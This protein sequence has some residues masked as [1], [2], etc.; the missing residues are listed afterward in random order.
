MCAEQ[1][2]SAA[3]ATSSGSISR[4]IAERSSITR[5]MTSCA[6]MPWASAWAAI[7]SS[8]RGVRT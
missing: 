8:T 4:L 5:S 2:Q 6:A 1:S 7:W 3:W